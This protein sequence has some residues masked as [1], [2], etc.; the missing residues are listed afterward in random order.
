MGL[1]DIS[2]ESE[3][4]MIMENGA[5]KMTKRKLE[6]LDDLHVV[7]YFFFSIFFFHLELRFLLYLREKK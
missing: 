1:L 3:E 7:H 2:K 6:K 5:K 4:W